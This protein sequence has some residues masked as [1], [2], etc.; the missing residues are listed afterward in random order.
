MELHV[1]NA[2]LNVPN[3]S[4]MQMNVQNVLERIEITVL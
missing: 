3:V 1:P 2:I 4:I